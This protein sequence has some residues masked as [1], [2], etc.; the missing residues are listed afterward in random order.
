MRG[1]ASSKLYFGFFRA[2]GETAKEISFDTGLSFPA[3]S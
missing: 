1:I 3:V 2:D